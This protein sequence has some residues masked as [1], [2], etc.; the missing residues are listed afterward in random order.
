MKTVSAAEANRHF[1]K[2]LRDVQAGETV[3]VTSRGRPVAQIQPPDRT[4]ADW[5][6]AKQELLAHLR[7][8]PLQNLNI[9]WTRDELYDD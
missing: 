9:T 2:L 6:K 7:T 1:S 3:L 4:L 5:E 8:R